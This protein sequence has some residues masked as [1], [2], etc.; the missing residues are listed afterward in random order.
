VNQGADRYGAYATAVQANVRAFD[1]MLTRRQAR[2]LSAKDPRVKTWGDA[3]NKRISKQSK[4]FQSN[5][6]YGSP[7]NPR[8]NKKVA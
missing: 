3:V 7:H 5:F 6:R 8:I 2:R 1:E 4:A